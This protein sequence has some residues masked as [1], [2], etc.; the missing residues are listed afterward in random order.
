MPS[1]S[2]E[3][4]PFCQETLE[5]TGASWERPRMWGRI[6]SIKLPEERRET[7]IGSPHPACLPPLHLRTTDP[8][9]CPLN[10]LLTLQL[11]LY[12]KETETKLSLFQ[13]WRCVQGAQNQTCSHQN[14]NP[15]FSPSCILNYLTRRRALET[16]KSLKK[17]FFFSLVLHHIIWFMLLTIGNTNA[18]LLSF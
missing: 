5:P 9:N 15:D 10:L 17:L 11:C 3:L 7:G 4:Q 14:T 13:K 1:S 8:G 6:L 16:Q 18:W 12:W 2:G